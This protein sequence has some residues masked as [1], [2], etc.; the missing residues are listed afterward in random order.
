MRESDW[1]HVARAAR[2]TRGTPFGGL[3]FGLDAVL[4]RA[5]RLSRAL[6]ARLEAA[7]KA[8]VRPLPAPPWGIDLLV[9]YGRLTRAG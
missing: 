2:N 3:G 8:R 5:A 9:L 1:G 7:G 6:D 4:F